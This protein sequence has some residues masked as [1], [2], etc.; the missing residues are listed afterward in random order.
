MII[1]EE[2][3][4]MKQY[5]LIKESEYNKQIFHDGM[6]KIATLEPYLKLLNDPTELKKKIHEDMM[7]RRPGSRDLKN[8]GYWEKLLEIANE[9]DIPEETIDII[10]KYYDDFKDG[11]VGSFL[12]GDIN[13]EPDIDE[14]GFYNEAVYDK[15][16]SLLKQLIRKVGY[17]VDLDDTITKI[18]DLLSKYP[19]LNDKL[20]DT[21]H[22]EI[23]GYFNFLDNYWGGSKNEKEEAKKGFP[24]DKKYLNGISKYIH[25]EILLPKLS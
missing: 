20:L 11:L 7:K 23:C 15:F 13:N 4:I 6:L 3:E 17:D 12:G 22:S 5:M 1:R 18:K 21:I 14:D 16:L 9:R 19:K 8:N 25:N 24:K 2:T 10:E